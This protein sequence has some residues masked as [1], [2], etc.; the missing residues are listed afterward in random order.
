[1]LL[2]STGISEMESNGNKQSDTLALHR[3]GG[4]RRAVSW[5]SSANKKQSASDPAFITHS[6]THFTQSRT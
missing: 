2:I 3:C 5:S 1:M 6:R 4:S